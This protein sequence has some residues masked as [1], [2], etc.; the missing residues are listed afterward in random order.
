[1]VLAYA[2]AYVTGNQVSDQSIQD[3]GWLWLAF[4]DSSSAVLD[5]VGGPCPAL[6]DCQGASAAVGSP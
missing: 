1:M 6:G 4:L 5:V 2:E 3:I